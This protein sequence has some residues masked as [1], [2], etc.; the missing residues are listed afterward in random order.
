MI[1]PRP[2]G[3]RA[4]G[5][6]PPAS[7]LDPRAVRH[8][9]LECLLGLGACCVLGALNADRIDWLRYAVL[10]AWIDVVGYLPGLVAHRL[11]RGERISPALHALYD[12][13]HSFVT[14]AG[15]ALV[16][17]AALGPEWALLALPTHLL[18]DRALFGNFF[19]PPELPFEPAPE[20]PPLASH[21]EPVRR[22]A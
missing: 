21:P 8:L 19:K 20:D 10:F 11:A 1:D 6:E 17:C 22:T 3:G 4:R 18:G 15:V 2:R 7:R 16:W 9:R 14:N 5:A 13:T 12:T